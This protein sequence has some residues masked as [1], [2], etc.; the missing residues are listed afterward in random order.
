MNVVALLQAAESRYASLEA[1]QKAALGESKEAVQDWLQ[2]AGLQDN[3]RVV[4]MLDVDDGWDRAVETVLGQYLQAV[5][6]SDVSE[7]AASLA[8]LH[9]GNV[10]L[11]QNQAAQGSTDAGTLSGKVRKAPIAIDRILRTVRVVDTLDAALATRSRLAE[12]ES[13]ITPD[14]V[15]ISE[16]WLRVSR[17][18]DPKSGILGREHEMRRLKNELREFQARWDSAKKLVQDGRAR[19]NQLEERRETLQQDAASLLTEYSEIKANLDSARF[20][21]DQA[22]ARTAAIAEES[23]EIEKEYFA[24]EEQIKESRRR[25]SH[26]VDALAELEVQRAGL[27]TQREELREELKRVR[28][29]ADNDRRAAHDIAIQFESRRSSK[30]SAAQS[31][32]RM[33]SQLRHFG[34]R[35]KD[36]RKQLED[37]ETPLSANKQKLEQQLAVRVEVETELTAARRTSNRRRINYGNSI[38]IVCRP[39]APP[40]KRGVQV[41][42]A[43][44]AMQEIRVRREGLA[45]QL[46]KTDFELQVLPQDMRSNLRDSRLGEKARQ[47]S[48]SHRATRPDQSGCDRRIQGTVG[49]QGIS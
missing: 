44:L 27:E 41:G 12:D 36:I 2:S 32:E 34:T 38:R 48:A 11:L 45:E 40:M 21:L 37:S 14:G 5:C 19:L 9:S 33:Q 7:A 25:F 13:V 15:W 10:T 18:T 4:K 24:A 30:L 8:R 42:E 17:D 3:A 46:G 28:E 35:E 39:T 43:K 16:S 49:A 47:D 1:V 20:Q 22:N 26:A 29:Q 6:V 31:L 23:N